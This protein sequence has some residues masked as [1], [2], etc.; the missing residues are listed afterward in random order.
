MKVDFDDIFV[1]PDALRHGDIGRYVAV[2]VR[3]VFGFV[4][5]Y[6]QVTYRTL[7]LTVTATGASTRNSLFFRRKVVPPTQK[8]PTITVTTVNSF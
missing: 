2:P 4:F 7:S 3:R 5:A 6:T 8:F 1:Q